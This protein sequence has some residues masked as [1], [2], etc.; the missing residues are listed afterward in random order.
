MDTQSLGVHFNCANC[1]QAG[2]YT[3]Q[4]SSTTLGAQTRK[5]KTLSAGFHIELGRTASGEPLI[6]CD[7]CDE[8]RQDWLF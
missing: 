6:V 3:W 8:I 1:G 7:T 4:V 2:T 5:L